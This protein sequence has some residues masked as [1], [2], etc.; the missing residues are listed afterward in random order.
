MTRVRTAAQEH[1][2]AGPAHRGQEKVLGR[3]PEHAGA[4]RLR[5]QQRLEQADALAS[6]LAMAA[7]LQRLMRAR[8]PRE[9]AIRLVVLERRVAL[10]LVT[11]STPEAEGNTAT[12][13]GWSSGTA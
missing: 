2:A 5:V 9:H 13:M 3:G 6:T 8:Q 7:L 12:S 4:A 10:V 1:E 11:P